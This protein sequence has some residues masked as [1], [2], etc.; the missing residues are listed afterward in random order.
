MMLAVRL[1]YN[2]LLPFVCLLA[3]GPWLLR[4]A[5]RGGL[6]NRLWERLG[7]YDRAPEWE[8]GGGVYVHAVSVGEVMM[9]LKMIGQWQETNPEEEFV[10]AATTSTGFQ[11]ALEQAPEGV[12]V[13]YSPLDL[14]FLIRRLF[15]RFEPSLI[16]LVDSEMWLNMLYLADMRGIPVALMNARLSP[17]SAEH[18]AKFKPI[19]M[20]MLRL[21][22]LVC[23]QAQEHRLMW[24]KI[25]IPEGAVEVTGSVKFDGDD[26]VPPRRRDE[27]QEMLDAF[28]AGRPIVLAASTHA[29]EEELIASAV[30]ELP[31]A[32]A[33]LFP[34][35]AERRHE[36]RA[37]LERAGMEVVLRSDFHAPRDPAQAVF[38]VD[39][40]GELRDW[41][42]H[43]D[44]VVIGKSFLARGGQNPTEAIVA[45]VPVICGRH[46][47]NFEPLIT[48]LRVVTG[49]RTVQDEGAL[50]ETLRDVLENVRER[51]KMIQHA[52][53]V[54]DGH[55]GA[56]ARTI[57][58]LRQ[59]KGK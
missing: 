40:T 11:L 56:T 42:A 33:V 29:G 38:V 15:N 50:V 35:H 2:L 24:Q 12:R 48:E 27:F 52:S 39:T 10:L 23:A 58:L 45:K 54:L 43:A 28:G 53:S 21:L 25:G 14:G 57:A 18:Y 32:L 26:L 44:V 34:R 59:L 49:V 31:G 3:A 7:C 1:L 37:D 47:E 22:K 5:R 19:T 9:A 46:M 13:I 6:S 55:R 17:R 51:T 16:V 30:R 8:S 20:P 41:T 4:M 36:V